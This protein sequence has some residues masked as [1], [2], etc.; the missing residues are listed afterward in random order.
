VRCA[1]RLS[2]AARAALAKAKPGRPRVAVGRVP[3]WPWAA[4]ALCDWTKHGFGIVA[5][6]LDFIFSEYIQ[7]LANSKNLCGIHL[8]SENYETNFVGKVLICT[9]L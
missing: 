5:L 6:E 3:A 7:F 1:G 2:W 4:P 9:R 8:N